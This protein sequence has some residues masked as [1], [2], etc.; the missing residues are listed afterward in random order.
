MWSFGVKDGMP[1]RIIMAAKKMNPSINRENMSVKVGIVS[2]AI[3]VATKERPQKITVAT[4]ALYV[5]SCSCFDIDPY[6]SLFKKEMS[7]YH[8]CYYLYTDKER[9]AKK[10]KHC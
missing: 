1:W 4:R 2:R 3:L 9:G 5:F 6:L 10:T 7:S 8:T